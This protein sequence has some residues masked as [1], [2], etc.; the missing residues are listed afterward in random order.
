M[1]AGSLHQ[2]VKQGADDDADR[3]RLD[4][5]ERRQEL[6]PRNDGEV[7]ERM[8]AM[9][10]APKRP[11]ELSTDEATAPAPAGSVTAASSGSGER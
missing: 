4:A 2:Q 9:A 6:A 11:R 3:Q 10:A 5:H 7:V 1:T 8:G